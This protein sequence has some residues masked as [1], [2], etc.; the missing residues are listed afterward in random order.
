MKR[1]ANI[2]ALRAPLALAA[3]IIGLTGHSSLA[4]DW[5][6]WRGPNRDG[7]S[8]ETGLLKTWPSGGPKMAWKANG[9]GRGYSDVVIIKDTIY[10]LGD[11]GDS[12]FLIAIGPD[13]KVKWSTKVGKPGSVGWGNFEGPRSTATVAGDK[14]YAVGQWGDLVCLSTA[15]GKEVWRKSYDDDFG[16][17]RPEWGY[18]ESPLIDGDK[19][20][21][22]PGGKNGAMVALNK[23]TGEVLW[24]STNITDQTQ[25]ASTMGATIAG[26][27]QYVQLSMAN[28][29]GISKDGA[30]LWQAPRK[31]NTAVIPTPIVQDDF[32]YVTSGY[33][34]GCNLFKVTAEGAKLSA[35]EV[36]ANKVMANHHGGVVLVD[37][38]IY[39]YSDGKGLVCQDFKTGDLVWSERAKANKGAVT[40]ADGMLYCREENNGDVILV[41]ASPTGFSEKGRLKQPDRSGDKAWSHPTICNGKLYLR[42]QDLLLCYDIKGK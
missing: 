12:S 26:I 40:Y 25:Y 7:K 9:L 11:K 42:D 1:L 33:T 16:A 20:I 13:H 27:P 10:T 22:F 39:G 2:S 36:Y 3:M 38:K 34:V 32:V 37:G 6:Q 5:P 28:V 17:E 4:A 18:S 35:Q 15:G 21:V 31:G 30:V 19:V 41:T 29:V 14:L 8:T 24:R 23:N